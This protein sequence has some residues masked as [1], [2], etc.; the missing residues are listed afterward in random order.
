MGSKQC[1]DQLPA[2]G[3]P[4]V[5]LLGEALQPHTLELAEVQL[6]LQMNCKNEMMVT[7]LYMETMHYP[8]I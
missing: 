4:Y 7:G 5:W 1:P 2:L 6:I 8:E 3:F